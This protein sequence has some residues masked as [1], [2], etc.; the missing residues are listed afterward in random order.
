MM[1]DSLVR[2]DLH[3]HTSRSHDAWMAPSTLVQRAREA[4]IDRI[5]VTDHGS[6][7]GA[8]EAHALDPERVIVAEE[9]GCAESIDLIGLFLHETIP[10]GLPARV[11][12]DRIREQ[13]GVV[14]GPHPYAYLVAA[15]RKAALV[16]AVADVVEVVNSRAFLPRWNRLA[17][18]AAG[19]HG[20]PGVANSDAHFGWEIGRC[21][22]EMPAFDGPEE[23]LAAVRQARLVAR[24][25]ASPFIHVASRMLSYTRL[26]WRVSAVPPVPDAPGAGRSATADR[27][28]VD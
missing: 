2:V 9:I 11:V 20:L 8:L 25:M 1:S 28:R 23:F 19:S 4:G 26:P 5:A 10:D 14:H 13:G 21:Y 24:Q 16:L 6:L 12:A 27:V 3:S 15:R 18:Q 22:S 7:G 17:R